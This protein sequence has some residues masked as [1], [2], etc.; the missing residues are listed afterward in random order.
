MK[1][2]LL[3]IILMMF[4][5]L[6][7]D[8]ITSFSL[9]NSIDIIDN[10]IFFITQYSAPHMVNKGYLLNVRLDDYTWDFDSFSCPLLSITHFDSSIWIGT[11]GSG[12]LE[13]KEGN[14]YQYSITNTGSVYGGQYDGLISNYVNSVAADTN[15]IYCATVR[16]LSIYRRLDNEWISYNIDNSPLSS[17]NI[18]DISVYNSQLWLVTSDYYYTYYEMNDCPSERG[19]IANID[20]SSMEWHIYTG[21]RKK[22]INNSVMVIEGEIPSL[23]SDFSNVSFDFLGR[24]WFSFQYGVGYLDKDNWTVFADSTNKYFRDIKDIHA[25]SSGIWV[26]SSKGLLKYDYDNRLTVYPGLSDEIPGSVITSIYA[27]DS[28]VVIKSY[29]PNFWTKQGLITDTTHSTQ[30]QEN[31][32]Y[33]SVM[34]DSNRVDI[35]CIDKNNW[36]E[37]YNPGYMEFL[38]IYKNG[39]W[40]SWEVT[41]MLIDK[42]IEEN[43]AT[44]DYKDNKC[45]ATEISIQNYPNPFNSTTTIC[46]R[47]PMESNVT[48]SIFDIHGRLVET[49]FDNIQSPGEYK[50]VWN[51]DNIN[52]GIYFISL[53]S[54][55]Y[56]S[57]IKCILIK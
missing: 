33:Y 4:Y 27:N 20:L 48:I 22:C 34:I 49:I 29:D 44:I 43:Y 51:A 37:L 16:G 23:S 26:A 39:N 31:P 17:D 21:L 9:N 8:I 45:F 56:K 30:L 5:S 6:Y 54:R 2:K 19:E 7:S 47:I 53:Y 15:N 12:V 14:I 28:I 57:V 46:Y 36:Q 25:N 3:M 11:Y 55:Y 38:T 32:I 13:I 41:R 1:Y 52:S 18:Y 40:Q 50:I 24:L 10:K 42:W 35:C